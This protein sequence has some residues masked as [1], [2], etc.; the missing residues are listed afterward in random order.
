MRREKL[1][2]KY[3]LYLESFAGQ[4]GLS[5]AFTSI[6]FLAQ[7]QIFTLAFVVLVLAGIFSEYKTSF[8]LI[9][10]FLFIFF[11]DSFFYTMDSSSLN[12]FG[13]NVNLSGLIFNSVQPV[14]FLKS[15]SFI[16]IILLL[17]ISLLYQKFKNIN[18]VYY[19]SFYF[20]SFTVLYLWGPFSLWG[21]SILLVFLI[22][23][24]KSFWFL[25]LNLVQIRNSRNEYFSPQK[26]LLFLPPL[27]SLGFVRSHSV[28]NG[29]EEIKSS[30]AV[31]RQERVK[32]QLS[33]LKLACWSLF[34][35]YIS[36]FIFALVFSGQFKLPY[37]GG[38]ELPT[39]ALPNPQK[40]GFFEYNLLNR[41]KLEQLFVMFLNPILYILREPVGDG[42]ILIAMIRMM[43][44]KARRQVTEP[45][46]AKSFNDFFS[47]V[48]Y[49]YNFLL[50]EFFIV[51][52]YQA[53]SE[54]R[55]SKKIRLFLAVFISVFLGGVL[56][57]FL[58]NDIFIAKFGPLKALE[59]TFGRSFY[60]LGVALLSAVSTVRN[61]NSE[62]ETGRGFLRQSLGFIL[63][64]AMYSFFFHLQGNTLRD[65]FNDRLNFIVSLLSF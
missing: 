22:I 24:A 26:T 1:F 30:M 58:R 4:L 18:P 33:G 47:R 41:D 25:C 28:P 44:I 38:F 49:Y 35:K 59:L 54:L 64:F 2:N 36:F 46:K 20:I 32:V 3:R 65:T 42:G 60:F 23:M 21:K 5:L 9:L 51:P 55:F 13:K 12:Y 48:Y 57:N 50:V 29:W 31:N 7:M 8:L 19:V 17:G 39:L 34:L 62:Q 11:G 45:Y 52:F 10:S 37:W 15:L 56:L 6:L 14:N 43:G 16:G 53:I 63:I 27:W 61:L 40:I